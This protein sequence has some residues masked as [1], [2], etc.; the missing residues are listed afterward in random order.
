[1][2]EKMTQNIWPGNLKSVVAKGVDSIAQTSQKSR[3]T[4]PLCVILIYMHP[5]YVHRYPEHTRQNSM[6][7]SFPVHLVN[8]YAPDI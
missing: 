6:F 4:L 8:I 1:M 5:K 2:F 7:F 3:D